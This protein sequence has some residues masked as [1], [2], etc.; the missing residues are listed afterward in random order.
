MAFFSVR[1]PDLTC[2]HSSRKVITYNIVSY[3]VSQG[4][5]TENGWKLLFSSPKASA[6]VEPYITNPDLHK[7]VRM[8]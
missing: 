5:R 3:D 7:V 8:K 6:L 1:A 2:L 4:I